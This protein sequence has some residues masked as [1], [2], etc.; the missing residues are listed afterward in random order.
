MAD[1]NA[2]RQSK[3]AENQRALGRK[4]RKIWATDKEAEAIRLYLEKLR[5]AQSEDDGPASA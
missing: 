4:A 3:Y 5:A 1:S 2:K